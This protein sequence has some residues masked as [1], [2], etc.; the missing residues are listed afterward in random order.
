MGHKP[1]RTAP[2]Y[3]GGWLSFSQKQRIQELAAARN[4]NVTGLLRQI[5]DQA[6]VAVVLPQKESSAGDRQVTANAASQ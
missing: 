1:N 3:I 6:I 5:A 4:T 2:A